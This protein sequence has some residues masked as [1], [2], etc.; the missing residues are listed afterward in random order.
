[1]RVGK[2][3]HRLTIQHKTET[4]PQRTATGAPAT[5]WTDLATVYGS[6]ETLSGRRLEVAQATWPQ[7][8]GESLI[9]YRGEVWDADTSSRP[10]R[11]S[12]GDRYYPIGKVIDTDGRKKELRILW[13]QGAGNG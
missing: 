11:I 13:K 10:M 3:R 6:L 5:A 7:A 4:S 9:R 12:F 2:L 1:M 8:T